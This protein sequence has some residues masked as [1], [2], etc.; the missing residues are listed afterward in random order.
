MVFMTPPEILTVKSDD[1]IIQ[2]VKMIK[3]KEISY[4]Y[5][6][7]KSETQLGKTVTF[8]ESVLQNYLKNKILVNAIN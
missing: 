2:F 8:S 6:Y 4:E 3:G 1:N 5:I 7:T